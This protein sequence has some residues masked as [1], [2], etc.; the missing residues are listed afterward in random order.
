MISLSTM[1]GCGL[2]MVP[3]YGEIKDEELMS[4]YMEISAI[5][6]RLKKP[7]GVRVLPI[8]N[9]K[10]G[11]TLYTAFHDDPDFISNTKVV[12]PNLNLLSTFKD[13]FCFLS[14]KDGCD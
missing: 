11:N 6:C 8:R 3:L 14:I 9:C 13:S 10:R 5:S 2:D 4:I 1:C 12:T 7:L